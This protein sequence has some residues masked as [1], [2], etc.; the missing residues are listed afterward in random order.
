M[1][2]E[3]DN[4]L[5][6]RFLRGVSLSPDRVAIRDGMRSIT[7]AEAHEL[8]LTWAG[9]LLRGCADAPRAI[10]VL[11]DKGADAYLGILAA[12]CCGVPVVPLQPDF[13]ADR[14]RQTLKAAKVSAL[15]TDDRGYRLLPDI[16]D[17]GE[18]EIPPVLRVGAAVTTA[19]ATAGIPADARFA[20]AEPRAASSSDAAYILFTSGSTGRPKGVVVTHGNLN[21]YFR[22]LDARYEF[23]PDD[24]FSQVFDP[25][26]D[27]SIFD[28]FGA[29]GCGGTLVTV[30]ARAYRAMPQFLSAERISIW[31]STP[32]AVSVLA[33]RGALGDNT[34][35][36]LRLS[37]F[38]GDALLA[39]DALA[40]QRAAPA[41]RVECLWGPTET[42][43]TASAY[44]WSSRTS[45]AE[46][47]NGIVPLGRVH[48]GHEW[49]LLD[50]EGREHPAEGE[51]CMRGPQ[52]TPGY[53]DPEDDKARFIEHNGRRWFRTG[54]RVRLAPNGD[55]LFLG[56]IDNQVQIQGWRI[57]LSEIDHHVLQLDG[58]EDAV[59]VSRTADG[60]PEMV[61][62]Y[63]GTPSRPADFSRQLLRSL[64]QAMVPR[65]YRH[66][67]E[68]PLTRNKKFDRQALRKL[69]DELR[70][71]R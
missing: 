28:L 1:T 64:P 15:V 67:D 23:T 11:A 31:Y 51:I 66:L 29:W 40:W 3:L 63:T 20:L 30:P 2:I 57:E 46:C 42:T 52:V 17:P 7:Y 19:S 55:L 68:M 43:I 16:L 54:D 26:F 6:G 32:A 60:R 25:T 33:R 50:A 41:S 10:G 36:T 21:H 48:A 39:G 35:P 45:P 49:F 34:F 24:V 62:F 61:V 9:S 59:T 58:V 13:P 18:A 71:V 56:R 69:A 38:A 14:I 5:H 27:C 37:T 4:T 12:L 47:L 44:R 53:L 8:C 22:I 70:K 65:H